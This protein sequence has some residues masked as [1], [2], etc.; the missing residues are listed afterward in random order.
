MNDSS[1]ARLVGVLF[2]PTSTFEAIRRRPTWLLP[3]VVLVLLGTVAGYLI[4][5][6]LDWESV[7]LEQTQQSGRQ[8]SQDQ[9]EASI[10][11]TEKVGPVM[12]IAGPMV[13]GPLAYLVM[14]LVFWV[15]L[16]L[17]GGELGYK[18][19]LAT[20]LHG[21]LPNAI[22]AV[23]LIPVILSRGELGI[24]EVNAG[25]VLASNAGAFAPE[26]TGKGMLAL[27][28]SIDVFSL[29]S[30]ALLTIGFSV[31]AGVSRAKSASVVIG[32]WVVYILFKLGMAAIS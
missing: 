5:Q 1:F 22:S 30:L 6:R 7:A 26:E 21:L 27:L 23:L 14:A 25:T 3:L 32:L 10:E 24:T 31:V 8:L 16:K 18:A 17:L 19:S 28:S 15:G 13:F 9:I 20:T 2:S 4:G 12:V 29:W 11:I